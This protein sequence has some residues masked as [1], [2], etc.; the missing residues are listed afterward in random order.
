MRPIA[1]S[2]P[3]A[4]DTSAAPSGGNVASSRARRAAGVEHGP[5]PRVVRLAV[6]GEQ[7]GAQRLADLAR[8]AQSL[9]RA[10]GGQ[11]V[12]VQPL[13]EARAVVEQVRA[14]LAI[15]RVDERLHDPQRPRRGLAAARMHEAGKQRF[16]FHAP[17]LAG[18]RRGISASR[19]TRGK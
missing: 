12:A 18:I 1:A 19:R 14:V 6:V 11:Q 9:G 17:S 16:A 10:V 4:C 5:R 15:D 3:S 2:T 13:G 7:Q 8:G